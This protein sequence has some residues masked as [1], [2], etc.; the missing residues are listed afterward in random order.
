[1]IDGLR[2]MLSGDVGYVWG[3][4]QELK[5][6]VSGNSEYHDGAPVVLTTPKPTDMG[7][8]NDVNMKK[9]CKTLLEAA[10]ESGGWYRGQAISVAWLRMTLAGLESRPFPP[11]AMWGEERA[12]A[13]GEP[14]R[15]LPSYADLFPE[16]KGLASRLS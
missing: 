4:D 13:T 5:P 1:M 9:Y 3:I 2:R 16:E 14:G 7:E 12:P 8:T 10:I 11:E 15:A 6:E